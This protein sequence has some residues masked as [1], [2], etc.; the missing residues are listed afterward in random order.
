MKHD[1]RNSKTGFP[2]WLLVAQSALLF[3]AA[4]LCI[5][6]VFL[7]ANIVSMTTDTLVVL[8]AVLLVTVLIKGNN[9]RNDNKN[10]NSTKEDFLEFARKISKN[11]KSKE[12]FEREVGYPRWFFVVIGVVFLSVPVVWVLK[13]F[14]PTDVVN[15]IAAPAVLAGAVLSVAMYRHSK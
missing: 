8:A 11:Y 6:G 7:P 10:S 3:S 2:K 1:N 9:M 4:L 14:L 13:I 5:L 12:D 15:L